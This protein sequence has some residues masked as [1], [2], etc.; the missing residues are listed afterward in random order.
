LLK[1]SAELRPISIMNESAEHVMARLI[2][3]QGLLVNATL[4][5][6]TEVYSALNREY[7]N[8]TKSLGSALY[9][10][11]EGDPEEIVARLLDNA[12]FQELPLYPLVC[13]EFCISDSLYAGE[14]YFPK[15]RRLTIGNVRYSLSSKRADLIQFVCLETDHLWN[16][17]GLKHV[18]HYRAD[19]G[20]VLALN[21]R[22]RTEEEKCGLQEWIESTYMGEQIRPISAEGFSGVVIQSG[23]GGG[24]FC[25]YARQ[26]ALIL[27]F[28]SVRSDPEYLCEMDAE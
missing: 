19:T 10:G 12:P 18:G 21:R 23:Y 6:N 7:E 17:N 22:R 8:L 14:G 28:S 9:G 11:K 1:N 15:K 4:S 3:L 13:E 16:R 5:G 24:G 27:D 25:V 2:E 20:C 26:H